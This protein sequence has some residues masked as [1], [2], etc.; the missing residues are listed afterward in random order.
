MIK[1]L[2]LF[3]WYL[4]GVIVCLPVILFL[5]VSYKLGLQQEINDERKAN[6]PV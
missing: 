1:K 2:L 6:K 4:L 3:V 5:F